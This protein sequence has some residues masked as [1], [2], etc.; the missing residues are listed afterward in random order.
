M[1]VGCGRDTGGRIQRWTILSMARVAEFNSRLLS[2][3]VSRTD[4]QLIRHQP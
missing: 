1:L 4:T 2:F 3:R